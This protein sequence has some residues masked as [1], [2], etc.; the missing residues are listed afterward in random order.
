MPAKQPVPSGALEVEWEAVRNNPVSLFIACTPDELRM[1]GGCLVDLSS[2]QRLAQV[3]WSGGWGGGPG[4]HIRTPF[5]G[6]G[7]ILGATPFSH[8]IIFS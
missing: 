4:E 3:M 1:F 6:L 7:Q 8:Q 5:K 2:A